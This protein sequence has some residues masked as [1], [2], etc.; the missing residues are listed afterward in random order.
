MELDF[1]HVLVTGSAGFI[2]FHL[3]QR[4]LSEGFQV[5][6]IDNLNDYY[7]VNLKKDRLKQLE[8]FPD[9]RF[10]QADLNTWTPGLSLRNLYR[11]TI[12]IKLAGL[13][14]V[15]EVIFQ[16]TVNPRQNALYNTPRL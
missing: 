8:Q 14:G 16:T 1:K 15:G 5:V 7:D 11:I 13:G 12:L 6:G 2:G 3:A 10:Q 9:F 4:L